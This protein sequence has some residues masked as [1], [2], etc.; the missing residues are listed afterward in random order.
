MDSFNAINNNKHTTIMTKHLHFGILL[1]TFLLF[2]GCNNPTNQQ[3]PT[4][5]NIQTDPPIINEISETPPEIIPTS[6]PKKITSELI[7]EG[8]FIFERS[9]GDLNKDGI[10]DSI[11]IVKKINKENIVIDEY[12][13]TVDRNRRGIMIFFNKEDKWELALKN[14]DCFSSE[15]ENGGVYFPPELDIGARKGN[16]YISYA[17]GRYGYWSYTFRFKGSDFELIGYD[18]SDNRGPIINRKTSINYLSKKKLTT[19]NINE[20]TVESG[21]EIYEETWENIQMNQLI[22]LSEIEDFDELDL[23][24]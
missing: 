8:Y 10:N 9:S 12:Q 6:D 21:D 17:H 5:E 4:P 2:Q 22:K 24:E 20:N 3:E 1:I 18:A 7:P 23:P 14:M 11:F 15:N 16:L 13:E 19:E